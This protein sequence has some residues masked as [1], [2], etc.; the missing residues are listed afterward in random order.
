MAGLQRHDDLLER[1]VAGALADA[2]DRA[3]DLPRAGLDPGQAVGHRHAQ[4]VVA[5]RADDRLADVADAFP[6]RANHGRILG[7]RGIADGVGDVDGGRTGLDG[8]LDDFAEEIELG[9]G[10]VLGGKLD[11]GAVAPGPAHAGHGPLDDLR[12]GHAQLVLAVDG[13]GCQEDVD[14]RLLGVFHGLPGAVDVLVVA[15]RQAAD[16]RAGD[17]AGNGPDRLEIADR[18]DRETRLDDIDPQTREHP[19]HF[20][21][22]DQIH[23][24]ARRL[25]AVAQGRVEDPDPVG[26]EGRNRG[27]RRGAHGWAL[28]E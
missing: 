21:L 14:P 26:V 18:G 7:G 19:R 28:S 25:L 23:A 8:R 24:R 20:E 22:L 11:V 27:L 9:P 12:G 6:E 13:R 4:V 3:L 1:G 17:L 2:V 10:G 5:V 16:G 15:P